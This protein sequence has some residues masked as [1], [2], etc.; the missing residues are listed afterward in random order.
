VAIQVKTNQ[1]GDRM[2]LLDKQAE[3]LLA[4]DLFYV[5]VD[6][7]S[8]GHYEFYVVPSKEVA[9][10]SAENHRAWLRTPGRK[11]QAHKDTSM[12]EF[13]DLDGRFRARWDLLSLNVSD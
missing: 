2:W 5:F 6:L 10:F 12:R 3:N 1:Q 4:D 13:K 9:R 7:R 11:G 8:D